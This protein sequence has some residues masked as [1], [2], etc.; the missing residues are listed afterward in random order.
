MFQDQQGPVGG[1]R[2][3]EI[4]SRRSRYSHAFACS[5]CRKVY[6][7][8][9]INAEDTDVLIL[10]L[11][12]S[13]DISCPISYQK[14]GTQN[15]TR[16]LDINML[17]H[18]LGDSV[19]DALVGMHAYTGCDTVQCICR[20]WQDE[21]LEVNEVRENLQEAFSELGRSWNVS[22]D[23]FEKLQEITGHMS[24]PAT[25]TSEVNKLRYQMFCARRGELESSQ[26]PPC[27]DCL[28]M[29]ALRANYQAAI[30]RQC[31]QSHPS[32][33]SP[34]SYGWTTDKDDQLVIEWMRGSPAPDAVLQLLSCKCL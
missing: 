10:C 7:V 15:R 1:Y 6:K 27:Q 34:K 5:S 14:C 12:F 28:S 13:K 3:P 18:S 23:L 2:R 24:V 20:P 30:W 26:L 9:V 16:F 31:L 21:C 29:H 17:V 11:G 33:P 32:V 4:F 19:Y 25:Y 8:V 22:P